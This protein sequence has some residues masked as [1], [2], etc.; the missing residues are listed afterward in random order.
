LTRNKTIQKSTLKQANEKLFD[1]A[2]QI[3]FKTIIWEEN[4]ILE[5][6]LEKC[7]ATVMAKSA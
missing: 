5:E 6:H 1:T 7:C 3:S 4:L 2:F